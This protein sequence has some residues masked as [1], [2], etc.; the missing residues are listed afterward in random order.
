MP[1]AYSDDHIAFA[2]LPRRHQLPLVIIK[3]DLATPLL[4]E[5]N[6]GRSY[7]LAFYRKVSMRSDRSTGCIDHKPQLQIEARWSQEGGLLRIDFAPEN[8]GQQLLVPED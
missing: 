8:V 1:S 3:I 2:K 4:H 7:D 6:F 5:Q